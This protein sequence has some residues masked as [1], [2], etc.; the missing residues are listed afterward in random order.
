MTILLVC[1]LVAQVAQVA[2]LYACWRALTTRAAT[3][4]GLLETAGVGR[5]MLQARIKAR[6]ARHAAPSRGGTHATSH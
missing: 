6:L 4:A 5:A 2:L 1:L 3:V